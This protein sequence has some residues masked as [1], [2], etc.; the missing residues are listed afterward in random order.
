MKTKLDKWAFLSLNIASRLILI[1]SFLQAIPIYHLLVIAT[2]KYILKVICNLHSDFLW[3]SSKNKN[4]WDLV[5][6]ET[7]FLPKSKGSIGLRDLKN[8]IQT[9]GANIWWH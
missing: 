2:P 8:L 3:G 6:W 7:I 5:A 1:K 4:K 9:L